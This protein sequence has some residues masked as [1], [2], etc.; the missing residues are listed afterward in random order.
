MNKSPGTAAKNT[1]TIYQMD[2]RDLPVDS[3][4]TPHA[5]FIICAKGLHSTQPL[6]QKLIQG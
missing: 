3:C 1:A 5:P 2:G 4:Q 6:N